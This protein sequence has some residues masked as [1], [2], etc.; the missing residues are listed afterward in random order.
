ML[1]LVV[2]SICFAI[3]GVFN[4]R[5]GRRVRGGVDC[6]MA[7][8]SANYWRDPRPGWRYN[9]DRVSAVSTALVHASVPGRD[10]NI[11]IAILSAWLK[12]W[13][14]HLAGDDFVPWH[15][16]FHLITCV[17]MASGKR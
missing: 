14:A 9:V 4:L 12:S 6:G 15:V 1:P 5:R 13:N 3:P 10:P 11:G 8:V 16:V 17:G 2:T 7:L